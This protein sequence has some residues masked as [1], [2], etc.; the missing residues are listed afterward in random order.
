V[1]KTSCLLIIWF[2]FLSLC[3]LNIS[4]LFLCNFFFLIS[5]CYSWILWKILFSFSAG[6]FSFVICASFC[7]K[8]VLLHVWYTRLFLSLSY[9][10]L[11]FV[12][13]SFS[14]FRSSLGLM[15]P[16][17]VV[18]SKTLCP[19]Y[20]WKIIYLNFL[21]IISFYWFSAILAS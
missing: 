17:Y 14:S 5:S 21:D 16:F 4:T 9:R 3:Y 19:I 7:H 11:I 13:A 20:E 1:S 12:M 10:H 15:Y 8:I 6:H 18:Y 2:T